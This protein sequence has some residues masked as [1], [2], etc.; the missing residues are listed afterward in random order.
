MNLRT[1][2]LN[3]LKVL[4][5]LLQTRNVTMASHELFIS[6]PAVSASLKKLRTLFDDSLLVKGEGGLLILTPK[7]KA[8][9]PSLDHWLKQGEDLIGTHGQSIIPEKLEYTFYVAL[10]GHVS[11]LIIPKLYAYIKKHAPL[12][13]IV[14]TSITDLNDLS[15]RELQKLDFII[16]TFK[17]IPRG[18]TKVLYYKDELACL[19]GNAKLNKKNKITKKDL[20]E[21]EHIVGSYLHDYTQSFTEPCLLS[22]GVNRQYRMIVSDIILAARL[23]FLEGL[24]VIMNKTQA[25]F[26]KTLYSLKIFPLPFQS[27]EI[28]TEIFYKETDNDN[29]LIM[30]FKS[31]L[32][33]EII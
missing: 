3:L 2:N 20:N 25:E 7:A 11:E 14:E 31:I 18:R 23:V 24:I 21:N 6:Q 12:V 9:K 27:P 26:A 15:A 29:S 10:Q 16:G 30:W 17:D 8:L 13:K 32:L 22:N 4:Q 19:S 1:I 5:V 33:N 28:K